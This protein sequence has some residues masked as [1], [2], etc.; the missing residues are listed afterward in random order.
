MLIWNDTYSKEFQ[1]S[2]V[3]LIWDDTYSKEF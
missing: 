2:S 1:I 3:M